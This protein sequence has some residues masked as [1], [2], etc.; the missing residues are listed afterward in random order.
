MK[1]DARQADPT[2]I[3]ELLARAGKGSKEA[4]SELLERYDPM[5]A[6]L[7]AR[8]S[9]HLPPE[10]LRDLRQEASIAFC[11]CAERFDPARGVG[12]GQYAKICV[13]NRIVSCLRKWKAEPITTALPLDNPGLLLPSDDSDPAKDLVDQENYRSLCGRIEVL[14]SPYE[15]RVW[16]LFISGL[17]A[18]EIANQLR[19]NQKSVENA[20]FRI[21]KKL[22]NAL[23]PR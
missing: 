12:F 2:Q 15:N 8:Y 17:T 22:R 3:D 14:L 5:I 21:R 18:R 9:E 10:L 20:V 6:A 16:L 23:L 7:I 19:E 11:R 4:A 1:S 13:R